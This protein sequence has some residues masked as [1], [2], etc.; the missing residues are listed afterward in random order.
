MHGAAR[1]P[2]RGTARR[3]LVAAVLTPFPITWDTF[4]VRLAPCRA[5]SHATSNRGP[6]IPWKDG[7]Q[8][9][10]RF[11][12]GDQRLLEPPSWWS[13]VRAWLI[14]TR[15][16]DFRAMERILLTPSAGFDGSVD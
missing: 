11:S 4:R 9:G 5:L 3:N 12:R 2:A 1:Q 14:N 7:G 15:V 10:S 16:S 8:C 13:T 6:G